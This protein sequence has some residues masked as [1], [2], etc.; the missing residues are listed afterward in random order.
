[1]ANILAGLIVLAL[2]H[3]RLKDAHERQ[4]L[5]RVSFAALFSFGAFVV[6]LWLFSSESSSPLFRQIFQSP[7]TGFL[8]L[9]LQSIFPVVL[10]L[11]ILRTAP[12]PASGGPS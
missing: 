8:F 10:A 5:R 4:R 3:K 9:I 12:Q 2:G 11:T 7:A 1:M 6:L